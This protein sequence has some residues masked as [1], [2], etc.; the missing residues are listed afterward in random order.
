MKL[1]NPKDHLDCDCYRLNPNIGFRMIDLAE[2]ETLEDD[3]RCC[4]QL[5]Y[6]Q[7]GK[8]EVLER[9][10]CQHLLEAQDFI[11]IPL[12]QTFSLRAVADSRLIVM[13]T[14]HIST[15]CLKLSAA[16]L[17]KIETTETDACKASFNTRVFHANDS[18]IRCWDSIEDYLE[19]GFSCK[20]IHHLKEREIFLLLRASLPEEELRTLFRPLFDKSTDFMASVHKY[21]DNVKTAQQLADEIGMER[22]YF[23]KVFKAHFN[24]SPYCWLQNLKAEKLLTILRESD[25]PIK[26]IASEMGFSSVSH[27]N[28]FCKKFFGK[29][30]SEIRDGQFSE[31]Q[32]NKQ[33]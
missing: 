20:E 1:I 2:K 12:G 6:L 33:K 11:F 10:G 25:I 3:E 26:N 18:L 9:G 15:L 4:N 7:H 27:L 23:Q 8:T 17:E 28:T 21:A 29:T 5:I 16:K 30:S 19:A 13:T 14:L 31:S 24:T 32:F 22:A